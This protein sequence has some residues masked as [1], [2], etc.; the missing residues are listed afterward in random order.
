MS[1]HHLIRVPAAELV[2]ALGDVARV[3]DVKLSCKHFLRGSSR[4]GTGV[5]KASLSCPTVD[6]VSDCR[7]ILS[8]YSES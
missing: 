5:F 6:H 7:G 8:I 4:Q 1:M 2:P 3:A